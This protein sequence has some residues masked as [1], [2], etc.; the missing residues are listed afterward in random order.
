MC[1]YIFA[2]LEKEE[3]VMSSWWSVVEV[4]IVLHRFCHGTDE[5]TFC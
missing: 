5:L 4:S 2:G 3:R 1:I